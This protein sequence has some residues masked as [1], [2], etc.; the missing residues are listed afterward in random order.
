MDG[1]DIY[2]TRG[3]V[4]RGKSGLIGYYYIRDLSIYLSI[5][6]LPPSSSAISILAGWDQEGE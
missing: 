4:G 1:M 2:T 5:I 6:I 3:V